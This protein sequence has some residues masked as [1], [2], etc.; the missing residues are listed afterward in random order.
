MTEVEEPSE[1]VI[2]ADESAGWHIA[3][4]RQL[5]RLLLAVNEF[6]S[7][8][9][10]PRV[11]IFWKDGVSFGFARTPEARFVDI[12]PWTTSDPLPINPCVL[13]THVCLFRNGLSEFCGQHGR[14]APELISPSPSWSEL[15]EKHKARCQETAADRSSLWRFVATSD[16]IDAAEISLLKSANKPQDGF[17]SRY[18]NRPISRLVAR[19]LLR[20]PIRPDQ[21]T[22]ALLILPLMAAAFLSRG[23]YS[24]VVVGAAIFQLFSI[25]DGCDGEIARAKYLDSPRGA[26][27][28]NLCDNIG[29]ILFLT[30]LSIGLYRHHD[31]ASGQRYLLEGIVCAIVIT[32]YELLL[33]RWQNQR[34]GTRFYLPS[35]YQRHRGML[36][37]SGIGVIGAERVGW[38]VQLTKRDLAIVIFLI[39]AIAGLPQWIIHLWLAVSLGS[40]LLTGI[41]MARATKI[42]AS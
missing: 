18:I 16:A 17:V 20:F 21:F 6:A 3:G 2:L 7:T 5:D 39:L 40:L 22:F 34:S 36:E 23:D 29:N 25:L 28:D 32:L 33:S 35:A 1:F 41:A 38:V 27:I 4:L 19:Q 37:H 42:S 8:Q 9:N 15:F 11:R 10:R 13:S 14:I 24:S 26:T 12:E 30:G 31:D